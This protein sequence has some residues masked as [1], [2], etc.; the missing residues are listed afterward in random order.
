MCYKSNRKPKV[1]AAKKA[2]AEKLAKT[3]SRTFFP[4]ENLKQ[5]GRLEVVVLTTVLILIWKPNIMK[6][7][8]TN[9]KEK[10]NLR[11]SVNESN[12]DLVY[13]DEKCRIDEYN[14]FF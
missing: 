11:T 14:T 3:Q 2:V 8:K 9:V 7:V 10:L 12:T 1:V 5:R 13:T 4:N 6:L